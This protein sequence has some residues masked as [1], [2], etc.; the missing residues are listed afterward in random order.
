[1][2]FITI[3]EVIQAPPEHVFEVFADIPGTG[4]QIS[5]ITRIE[6]LSEGPIGK[7]TRWRET[8]IMFGR[9]AVEEMWITE[10]EPPRGYSAAAESHGSKYL[11]RYEFLPEGAGTRVV[12]NF[13]A[14]GQTFFAK[15]MGKLL[16]SVM[17]KS[18]REALK[19]DMVELKQICEAGA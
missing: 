6:M 16:F 7:G 17:V 18:V 13:G 2:R 8:R 9:E 11:T 12:L 15:L 3:E 19:K 14:E 1:M 5:A 4:A 10:F